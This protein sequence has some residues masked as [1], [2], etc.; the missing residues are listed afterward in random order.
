MHWVFI[1]FPVSVTG[2]RGA[3]L[4]VLFS[5][6]RVWGTV[7]LPLLIPRKHILILV[8]P[9][10]QTG[11]W[12]FLHIGIYFTLPLALLCPKTNMHEPRITS[13]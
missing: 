9:P 13:S 10:E 5:H 1:P 4:Q 12:T 8:S 7:A 6:Q 2:E 11:C 3:G